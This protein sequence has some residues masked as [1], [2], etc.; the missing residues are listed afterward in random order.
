MSCDI[1]RW[2]KLCTP[3]D[4]WMSPTRCLKVPMKTIIATEAFQNVPADILD[5][6]SRGNSILC[7]LFK[8]I[9]PSTLFSAPFQTSKMSIWKLHL[10]AWQRLCPQAAGKKRVC[11]KCNPLPLCFWW[12][13]VVKWQTVASYWKGPFQ[14]L[15]C[16]GSDSDRCDLFCS[17]LFHKVL[18]LDQYYSL[19]AC[20][21]LVI[22][23][24]NNPSNRWNHVTHIVSRQRYQQGA[25]TGRS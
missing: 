2:R 22:S 3:R 17:V 4:A 6:T 9:S 21:L 20:F 5:I 23:L 24:E 25:Q 8:I 15:E 14:I 10:T 13:C 18:C 1:K 19:Y 7:L 12:T 11:Q 16:L